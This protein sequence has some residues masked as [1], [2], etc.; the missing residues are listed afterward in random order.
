MK[1]TISLLLISA[2]A[3][4]Q[5]PRETPVGMVFGHGASVARAPRSSVQAKVGELLMAGDRITTAGES[6]TLLSCSERRI[7]RLAPNSE[8]T[9]TAQGI[10]AAPG[11]LTSERMVSACFLPPVKRMAV[12]GQTHLGAATMRGDAGGDPQDSLDA[13]IEALPAATRDELV[14][15]LKLIQGGDAVASLSRGALFE[16]AGL[17]S[18]ASAQYV[19]ALAQLP[20]AAWIQ[21]K[22]AEL[23]DARQRLANQ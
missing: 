4:A 20:G 21:H 11:A 23:A 10:E 5:T 7:V 14:A 1:R 6:A 12:A 13:R 19:R 15:A 22:L 2:A 17:L 9:V 16:K 18:D 8:A 3:L